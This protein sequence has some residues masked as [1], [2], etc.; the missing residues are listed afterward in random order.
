M[1]TKRTRRVRAH[2]GL[3]ANEVQ[4]LTGRPQEGASPLW[5]FRQWLPARL[6]RCR[7]L[8]ATHKHLIPRGRM[9]LLLQDIERWAK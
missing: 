9:K 2:V 7:M 4:W 1:P 8:L 5:S 6:E 3:N